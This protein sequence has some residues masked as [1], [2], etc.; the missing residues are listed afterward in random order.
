MSLH[1]GRLTAVRSM[2]PVRSGNR[3]MRARLGRDELCEVD[4]VSGFRDWLRTHDEP[5][6]NPGARVRLAQQLS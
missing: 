1:S 3:S 5:V 2:T 4:R 6:V